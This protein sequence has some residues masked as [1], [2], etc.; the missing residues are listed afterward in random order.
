MNP[1]EIEIQLSE[2]VDQPF[3]QAEF[4][5]DFI[6][7][8][9][10][11]KATLTKIRN[12]QKAANDAVFWPQKL[13]FSTAKKG[14]CVEVVDNLK[15][16]KFPKNKAPRILASTD[17]VEFAAY[18]SKADE[19]LYCDVKKLY[20]NFKFFYPLAGIDQYKPVEENKADVKA[21]GRLAKFYDEIIRHNPGWD[22]EEKRHALNQFMTRVLFCMFSEDTGSFK[23]KLFVETITEFGGEDGE[24]L[25][26]RF[27]TYLRCDGPAAAAA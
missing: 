2:L 23:E 8:F 9:K 19:S 27:K 22:T 17:G 15:Q 11:P 7:T 16:Q 21:A 24:E 4:A 3:N 25:H 10:P 13:L 1:T 26:T 12:S 6:A 18:D 20:E 14:Q 5:F